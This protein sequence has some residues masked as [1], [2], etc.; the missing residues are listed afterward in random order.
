MSAI[1]LPS[2]LTPV[3]LRAPAAP[4]PRSSRGPAVARASYDASE[5]QHTDGNASRWRFA[6]DRW[7][8]APED[9]EF[10]LA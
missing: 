2:D 10:V 3:S 8:P 6:F 4:A 5:L 7:L 1:H 9:E